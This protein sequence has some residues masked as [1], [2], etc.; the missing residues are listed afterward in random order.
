[1]PNEETSGR[2]QM[3]H[4]VIFTFA[5]CCMLIY[6]CCA[7]SVW[8]IFSPMGRRNCL[9]LCCSLVWGS[10]SPMGFNSMIGR[11]L[12][13]DPLSKRIWF[14][15]V[16][17]SCKKNCI[18]E[19]SWTRS[20]LCCP[21]LTPICLA[22]RDDQPLAVVNRCPDLIRNCLHTFVASPKSVIPV[23]LIFF[24]RLL[25]LISKYWSGCTHPIAHR[26]DF[27]SPLASSPWPPAEMEEN[28]KQDQEI[29]EPQ[30]K[31]AQLLS[32]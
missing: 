3:F 12:S 27:E 7:S 21:C 4:F 5:T 31:S 28:G 6:I 9:G 10:F 14:D 25:K 8:P 15:C 11:A 20:T 19:K 13:A 2:F 18:V 17:F 26:W 1:M 22:R 23:D 16:K 32:I 24:D 29:A 30:L